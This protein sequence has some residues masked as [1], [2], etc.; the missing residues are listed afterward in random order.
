MDNNNKSGNVKTLPYYG[1]KTPGQVVEPLMPR[2]SVP[3]VPSQPATLPPGLPLPGII[4]V[5]KQQEEEARQ[6]AERISGELSVLAK[7]SRLPDLRQLFDNPDEIVDMA[8]KEI[9][10][11]RQEV[12][13]LSASI[14][15]QD[16]Q[17]DVP[18]ASIKP[19]EPEKPVKLSAPP[20]R[21][22][23][24]TENFRKAVSNLPEIPRVII[25]ES[26]PEKSWMDKAKEKIGKAI[27]SA[28]GFFKRHWRGAAVAASVTAA[29][30]TAGLI[31]NQSTD[32][33][34]NSVNTSSVQL[35]ENKPTVNIAPSASVAPTAFSLNLTPQ[36]PETVVPEIK[37]EK[38]APSSFEARHFASVLE[39]SRSPL[40]QEIIHQ[41]EAR[42]NGNTVTDTMIAPFR[43]LATNAQILELNQLQK[44]INLGISVYFNEHFGTPAKVAES[45]KDSKLKNLYRT[46]LAE[47]QSGRLPTYLTKEKFPQEYRLAERIFADSAELG[48]DQS[49][50][51]NARSRDYVN[52]NMFQAKRP[53]DTLI[54]RKN[55]GSYHVILEAVFG[56]L[57]G[58][59]AQAAL[60]ENSSHKTP[61]RVPVSSDVGTDK[62]VQDREK[63]VPAADQD[64]GRGETGQTQMQNDL[65]L[66][67]SNLDRKE[68]DSNRLSQLETGWDKIIADQDLRIAEKELFRKTRT[69]QL[70]L[71]AGLTSK[72]EHAAILPMTADKI[73]ALYPGADRAKIEGLMKRYGFIG[74]AGMKGE[75]RQ[76]EVTLNKNFH[77]ILEQEI[78]QTA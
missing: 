47:K 20:S 26:L 28:V 44:S 49:D 60:S 35:P 1:K 46:A 10:P 19:S 15:A 41:G 17:A 43:G 39:N 8:F 37:A 42:L 57:E 38:P 52:G 75:G 77:R 33:T 40:V 23:P 50:S 67:V 72:Q 4:A 74:I 56:I 18:T 5:S 48:L 65:P 53:G 45:L 30:G 12:S 9:K 21:E 61:E 3:Q 78:L 55:N 29:A 69:L 24:V 14:R 32:D 11:V 68:S 66:G 31:I 63:P 25:N 70:Q 73:A 16:E 36:V 27:D 13:N 64:K 51:S 2:T 59:S 22:V 34:L 76:K 6:N 7:P 71:D 62:K 58:K 54:L